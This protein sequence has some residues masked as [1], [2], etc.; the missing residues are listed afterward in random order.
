MLRIDNTE[1]FSQAD[2]DLMN[3]SMAVL[4]GRG[5]DESSASDIVNNN[6]QES[7]NTVKTLVRRSVGAPAK[8]QD[9]KRVNIYL[10]AESRA[11][12]ERIG[13]GN[14]SEGIRIAL[15]KKRP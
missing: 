3:K 14:V 9:G 1:G 7:G 10:S 15:A 4:I 12:A 13:G 5:L 6:W 2:C 11:A 8:M